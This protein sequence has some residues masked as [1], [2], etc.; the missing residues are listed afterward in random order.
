[1]LSQISWTCLHSYGWLIGESSIP[2]SAPPFHLEGSRGKSALFFFI[3]TSLIFCSRWCLVMLQWQYIVFGIQR[4]LKE[5][6]NFTHVTLQDYHNVEGR[7]VGTEYWKPNPSQ[8]FILP[9]C[10]YCQSA[11]KSWSCF[12]TLW[13]QEKKQ[14]EQLSQGLEDIDGNNTLG[15]DTP[16]KSLSTFY[17]F[18]DSH[19]FFILVLRCGVG[20][21]HIRFMA[22][23]SRITR[24]L[25]ANNKIKIHQATFIKKFM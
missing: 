10:S 2:S 18:F 12:L 20:Q 1:M 4:M 9:S 23:F 25:T 5:I 8:V 22:L 6:H 15:G 3:N 24:Y 14:G 13:Q 16:I 7:G 21:L 11:K 17:T 19:F